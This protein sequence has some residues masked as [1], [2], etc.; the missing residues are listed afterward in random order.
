LCRETPDAATPEQLP[1]TAIDATAQFDGDALMGVI[2]VPAVAKA[3]RK[4]QRFENKMLRNYVNKNWARAAD[5][6]ARRSGGK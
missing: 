6:I 2:S 5:P 1:A 3:V 4:E